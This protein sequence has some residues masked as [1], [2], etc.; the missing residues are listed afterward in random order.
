MKEPR[1]KSHNLAG[2]PMGQSVPPTERP[3]V[4]FLPA[5]PSVVRIMQMFIEKRFE[6]RS[7]LGPKSDFPPAPHQ[8]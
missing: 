5:W 4:E 6:L 7:H 2:R 1:A 8:C 3:A